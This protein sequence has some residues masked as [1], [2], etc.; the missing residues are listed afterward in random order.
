MINL[1]VVPMLTLL[2][3]Y[4]QLLLCKACSKFDYNL[5]RSLLV[6]NNFLPLLVFTTT[7]TQQKKQMISKEQ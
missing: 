1:P 7:K 6:Q 4:S 2:T 5:Q 3:I